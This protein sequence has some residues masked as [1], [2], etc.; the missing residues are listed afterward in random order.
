MGSDFTIKPLYYFGSLASLDIVDHDDFEACASS[1]GSSLFDY[2]YS[3][4]GDNKE[5]DKAGFKYSGPLSS[6][7]AFIP[8]PSSEAR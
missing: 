7:N 2:A 5:G 1:E 3:S 8:T 4:T 6:S